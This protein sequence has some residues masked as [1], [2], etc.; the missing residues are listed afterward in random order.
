MTPPV[1]NSAK[2]K[3]R[4]REGGSKVAYSEQDDT[5]TNDLNQSYVFDYQVDQAIRASEAAATFESPT[6]ASPRRS[7]SSKYPHSAS[8][9]SARH[10]K[11]HLE[12]RFGSSAPT[13]S[14]SSRSSQQSS[15][16]PTRQSQQRYHHSVP[17][18]PPLFNNSSDDSSIGMDDLENQR[19]QRIPSKASNNNHASLNGYLGSH[20]SG[21]K[22]KMGAG[23]KA[24]RSSATSFDNSTSGKR[25][26]QM[27]NTDRLL[28]TNRGHNSWG[29]GGGSL[30]ERQ[31]SGRIV[32][33]QNSGRQGR[34]TERGTSNNSRP[35]M[36]RQGSKTMGPRSR[37]M[38]IDR[39]GGNNRSPSKR[40]PSLSQASEMD[41][42]MRNSTSHPT[43]IQ[44]GN[45]TVV[46]VPVTQEQAR[47]MSTT[48]TI[49]KGRL[50]FLATK[51]GGKIPFMAKGSIYPSYFPR[52]IPP[53]EETPPKSLVLIWVV[54][55]AELAFDLATTIIAFLALV[56]EDECC[57]EQI[58]L[59]PIPM[60]VTA[61]F[62]L[63]VLAELSFLFRAV[64]LT[65]WP[66]I[67]T[68]EV[69]DED[70]EIRAARGFW[71]KWLCCW[72]RWKAKLVLKILNFLV[73]LNP[74]F[75]CVIAWM[76]LYQ[77]NKVEAFVVLGLEGGSILLHFFSVYLEGSCKTWGQF[78]CHCVPLIP[79]FISIALILFYLKQGGVCYL[80]ESELFVFTGCELCADGFPPVDNK[81]LINGVNVT[82]GSDGLF[83]F[84]EIEGFSDV[85]G[86]LKQ[87][88]EQGKYCGN[89]QEGEGAPDESFCFFSYA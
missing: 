11:R 83:N 34:S 41:R 87:R 78:A 81:C 57:G 36:T 26:V 43:V 23:S 88:V 33:R 85:G 22:K 39:S 40:R 64:V 10:K 27:R 8:S 18:M 52:K 4:R 47:K 35:S 63:L 76:L 82:V 86:A 20:Q 9:Q 56:E 75:G 53:M 89:L 62:F 69:T 1:A 71:K 28:F 17:S 72:L 29:G 49:Q 12:T 55:S 51:D 68:G 77:S 73:L 30:M 48:P 58:S 70:R 21:N 2:V 19:P 61:P 54:V 79:F 80:V 6:A 31:D 46:L 24:S 66:S 32:T 59:G 25:K 60:T 3:R 67:F 84:D 74:F 15:R 50:P 16:S 65:L 44:Q 14:P 13:F 7:V 42:S 5:T 45:K 38:S 37:S